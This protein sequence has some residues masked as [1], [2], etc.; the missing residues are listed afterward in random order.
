[1]TTCTQMMVIACL[2]ENCPKIHFPGDSQPEYFQAL[3]TPKL[4][5]HLWVHAYTRNYFVS[6][7][8]NLFLGA[9]CPVLVSGFFL[10]PLGMKSQSR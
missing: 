6:D 1:M 9:A 7:A 2:F 4:L 5:S 3:S 10:A 8:P